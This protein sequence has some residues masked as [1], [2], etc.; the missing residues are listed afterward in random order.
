VQHVRVIRALLIDAMGTLV[1]LEPPVEPL[2]AELAQRFGV[3]VSPALAEAALHAEIAFYRAHMGRGRDA[4]S[5]AAL[6]RDCAEALRAA[7]PP[8]AELDGAQ[9]TEALLAALRFR[10]YPDA[11]PG[12]AAVRAAGV[13]RVV[14]VSNWDASLPDVL[15][16]TGLLGD[17]DA[18]VTSAASGAAKPAPEIFAA[19]LEAAGVPATEALHVGD[20]L[21]EDVAGAR[22][23]G[24]VAV[25]LD[26]TGG[27]S[28]GAECP[29]IASLDQLASLVGP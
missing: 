13:E 29:V 18:V 21:A 20:S 10:A 19:A 15:E 23:A 26:R 16:R 12:L 28:A 27:R 6:R 11:A 17:V 3:A 1:A 25:L 7:L 22:A 5:L 9:L 4:A 8:V 2:R 14:V 24:V